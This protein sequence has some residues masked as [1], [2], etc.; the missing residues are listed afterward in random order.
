MD[1]IENTCSWVVSCVHICVDGWV[2]SWVDMWTVDSGKWTGVSANL[3]A[4]RWQC[5]AQCS[6]SSDRVDR[7]EHTSS[8]V[9]VTAHIG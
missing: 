1:R 6:V 5:T 8:C 4:D 7:A 3:T 9:M 2:V